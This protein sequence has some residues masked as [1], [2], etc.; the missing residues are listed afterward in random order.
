M[1]EASI[2]RETQDLDLYRSVHPCL[3]WLNSD[4]R[5]KIPIFPLAVRMMPK[6][7]FACSKISGGDTALIHPLWRFFL[8]FLFFFLTVATTDELGRKRC[9]MVLYRES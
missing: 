3:V 1:I 8:Y 2:E 4:R 7:V 9:G 6:N 5:P